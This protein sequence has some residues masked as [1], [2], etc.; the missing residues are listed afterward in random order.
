L[1]LSSRDL[2]VVPLTSQVWNLLF[3]EFVLN[4]WR[5][6][7]LNVPSA[8]KRGLY[9]VHER[10]IVKSIGNLSERDAQEVQNSLEKWLN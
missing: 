9:T 6:S 5:E 8:V 3:G 2:F 7:G 1:T 10:L 4:D